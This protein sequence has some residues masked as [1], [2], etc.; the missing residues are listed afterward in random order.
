[1]KGQIEHEAERFI[2]FERFRDFKLNNIALAFSR[3]HFFNKSL[4]ERLNDFWRQLNI[5]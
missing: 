4:K 5:I 1:M 3:P 2:N